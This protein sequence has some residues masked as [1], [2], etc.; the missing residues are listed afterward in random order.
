MIFFTISDDGF[1]MNESDILNKWIVI[2]TDNKKIVT[3]YTFR[4]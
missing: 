3:T 4:R 2:G 1:G